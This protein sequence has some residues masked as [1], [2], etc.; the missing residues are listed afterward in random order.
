MHPKIT[1]A[2][3]QFPVG[4]SIESNLGFIL[5]LTGEAKQRG[6]DIAHFCESSLSGYAGIDFTA[7]DPQQESLLANALHRV[8]A[9][10][11]QL[12]IRVVLGSHHFAD[13]HPKPYNCLWLIDER[14]SL[15]G[16]YDKR[17]LF[18]APG[19][20]EHNHYQAGRQPLTF[21]LKD[22]RCGLL[23]CHEWRY[24]ELYR[25]QVRLGTRLVFQS[26][27]DGHLTLDDF[28][29][30]GQDQ[31]TLIIGTVRGYAANNGLWISASNTSQRESCFAGFVVRPDGRIVHQLKRNV[32]G[33]L[34]TCI[35]PGRAFDDPSMPWRER[36]MQGM[37]HNSGPSM[38]H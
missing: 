8:A 28:R 6:A 5:R 38:R 29:D 1:I 20:G 12:K 33:V 35:D 37:L 22:I 15:A 11:G 30:H 19:E 25:E 36:A 34:L 18:G 4:K 7:F 24:P 13:G 26:W 27:Y 23:I 16:R 14:G 2:T 9:H 10:A 3:C 31:G 17:F 32:T 21:M